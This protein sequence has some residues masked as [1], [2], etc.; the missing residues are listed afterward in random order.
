MTVMSGQNQFT[1]QLDKIYPLLSGEDLLSYAK[2]FRQELLKALSNQESSL[3]T[4]L[5]PIHR[6]APTP[7]FGVAVSIGGTNGYVSAFRVSK[8]GIVKFINRKLFFLPTDTTEEKLFHLI[9]ENVFAVAPKRKKSFPIGIGFAYPLKPLLHHG[10]IDGELI[11]TT[12]GRNIRGLVGKRVGQ[13]FHK[14]LKN[15]HNFDTKVSVA[16]DAICL[17]LG[18]DGADVAGVVGTGLNFAYWEKRLAIAP[19][20]LRD[21]PGFGQS[22]V[23]V[24]IESADF[25]KINDTPL[26]REIDKSSINPGHSLAEKEASGAYLFQIFNAGKNRLMKNSSL[27]DL[28]STDQLND[29]ITHAYKYPSGFPQ[30]KRKDIEKLAYRI[31]HRS[32]QIVAVELCGVLMKIGQTKGI[33]PVV[34]EGGIF[35]KANNYPSLVNLYVNMILP[36]AIPSFARLFGSSRRGIAILAS[37]S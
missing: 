14:Y 2:S 29:I 30:E 16:N 19:L 3:P 10:Y 22:D 5:N 23:A 18:G 36:E 33:V 26:L 11:Y 4:I 34:M 24:N 7:T 27:P 8:E 12:K 28:T 13:E 32:A 15:K 25:D 9:A 37:G 31:F 21:L 20:K 35:W 1:E 17:L 6:M